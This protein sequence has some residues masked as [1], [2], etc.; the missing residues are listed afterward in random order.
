[1]IGKK[2]RRKEKKTENKEEIKGTERTL[3]G[4]MEETEVGMSK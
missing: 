1:M 4:K 3:E 2:E